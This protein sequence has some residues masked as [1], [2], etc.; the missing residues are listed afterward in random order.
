MSSSRGQC[1]GVLVVYVN[2][3]EISP[4]TPDLVAVL[5][6]LIEL[7]FDVLLAHFLHEHKQLVLASR[8]TDCGAQS[9]D[10]ELAS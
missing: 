6:Q 8:R 7:N 9:A 3:G 2:L 1:D 4:V 10:L 5:V